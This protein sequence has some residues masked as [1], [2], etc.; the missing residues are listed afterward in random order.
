MGVDSS[1]LNRDP[2]DAQCFEAMGC[3]VVVG[4]VGQTDLR[5]IKQAFARHGRATGDIAR[6]VA[7]DDAL[8]LIAGEGFVSAGSGLAVRGSAVVSLPDGTPLAISDTAIVTSRSRRS[9]LDGDRSAP[10]TDV[11][12]MA[13]TCRDA[14]IAAA[15]ALLCEEEGPALLDAQRLPG[16][17]LNHDGVI[18]ENRSWRRVLARREDAGIT[19]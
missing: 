10:W 6:A 14:A 16:R 8:A 12:V 13:G 5:A 19:L 15:V 18:L 3:S 11:S 17:F 4:G 2:R 9:E 7:V 1:N